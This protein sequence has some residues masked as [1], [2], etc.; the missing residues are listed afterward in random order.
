MKDRISIAIATYN[1]SKYLREQLESIYTQSLPPHEVV[2]SDDCSTDN[3]IEILEEYKNAHGLCYITNT[4]NVGFTR[5]F[6]K[7]ILMATGEYVLP[8]DQ[9]DI[10]LPDKIRI[11]YDAIK[12]KEEEEENHNLPGL[13]C[14]HT[15]NIDEHG[16]E[17]CRINTR[18]KGWDY[19]LYA[20]YTQGCT[21]IMNRKLIQLVLPI[22]DGIMYDV[23]IGMV[24]AMCGFW[25]NN[26]LPLVKYR[27]HESNVM[28]KK[29]K[30][31]DTQGVLP[32]IL[33]ESRFD[34]MRTVE[35]CHGDRFLPHKK[36]LFYRIYSYS[37]INKWWK[38]ILIALSFKHKPFR[39][40]LKSMHQILIE[41]IRTKK[42]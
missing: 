27:C 10:W 29:V 1:G 20:H 22:P 7:A 39:I 33:G 11:L 31:R 40:K 28:N 41:R 2:V 35:R 6:E 12:E 3:T 23:Y 26:G 34:T 18:E 30:R 36:E 16:H 9:D 32:F 17:T 37:T 8:C 21:L 4:Q 14:S 19:L 25:Y 24:A 5:N 42:H 13:V 38:R 15:I